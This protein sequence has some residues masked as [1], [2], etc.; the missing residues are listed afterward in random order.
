MQS[1]IPFVTLPRSQEP[2]WDPK[3]LFDKCL[4]SQKVLFFGS[5]LCLWT[6]G[7]TR[8]CPLEMGEVTSRDKWDLQR[9]GAPEGPSDSERSPSQEG[10]GP[11]KHEGDVLR[12]RGWLPPH[13]NK[14]GDVSC[15]ILGKMR[16]VLWFRVLSSLSSHSLRLP[17]L[18]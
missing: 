17:S 15:E 9:A 2:L 8:E 11:T 1:Q 3:C 7:G 6:Y 18:S 14:E 13:K 16:L 12:G 5:S 4:L 10:G